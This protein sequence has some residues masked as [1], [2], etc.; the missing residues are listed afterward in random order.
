MFSETNKCFLKQTNVFSINQTNIQ[1]FNRSTHKRSKK[2]Q[3]SSNTYERCAMFDLFTGLVSLIKMIAL[4]YVQRASWILLY[5]WFK[6]KAELGKHVASQKRRSLWEQRKIRSLWLWGHMAF[7][8]RDLRG[9]FIDK[10]R[11][12]DLVA[13][14]GRQLVLLDFPYC[15][16]PKVRVLVEKQ[17]EGISFLVVELL[18]T[19]RN[20]LFQ[21]RPPA[22]G[23]A[24][25]V[26]QVTELG[27]R[28]I[29]CAHRDMNRRR[30]EEEQ[31]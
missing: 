2:P 16:L 14:A 22:G 31:T 3:R 5:A 10:G 4:N 7:S 12:D 15:H 25:Q 27:L 13:L 11:R 6:G 19:K 20:E 24:H 23:A 17:H 28:E 9:C 18:V 29:H 8:V 1:S 26:L 21:L 30:G